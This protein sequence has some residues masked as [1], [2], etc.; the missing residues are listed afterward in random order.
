MHLDFLHPQRPSSAWGWLVLLAGLLACGA[1]LNWY[2]FQ[3]QP[4][5][6]NAEAD[7]DRARRQLNPAGLA[8]TRPTDKH[9]ASDWKRAAKVAQELAAPWAGVFDIL[10]S[11]VEQPIALLSLDIDSGRHEMVL[12]GEARNYAAMLDYY[13]YL[14]RQ[15]RLGGVELQL[16]QVNRQDRDN[17]VRFR[18]T[19][20]WEGSV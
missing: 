4:Q 14:Q 15:K 16:H 3:V 6:Q 10:D 13:S 20:H 8:V 7:L 1:F 5:L 12:T 19:A 9:L 18:M 2:L 11:A 17:P